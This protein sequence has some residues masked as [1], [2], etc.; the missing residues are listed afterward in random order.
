MNDLY[1]KTILVDGITYYYNPD[2]DCYYRRYTRADLGH[3]DTYGWIYVTVVLCV[4]S[5]YVEYIH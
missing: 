2:Y 5:Y 3:W 1:E 4:I